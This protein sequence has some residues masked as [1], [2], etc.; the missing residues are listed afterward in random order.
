MNI[1][2]KY[3]LNNK[4]AV[5][6]FV[7]GL[8]FL[9]LISFNKIPKEGMP[10]LELNQILVTTTYPGAAPEDVELNVTIPL[11]EEINE[12]T[13]IDYIES[14]SADNMS[15]IFIQLDES[16]SK[17]EIEETVRDIR[18][19]VETV[20]DLPTEVEDAPLVQELK[21]DDIPIIEIAL[22][23]E[24]HEVLRKNARKL[25]L[26]LER[27]PLVSG[28]DKIGYFDKEIHIE[29]DPDALNETYFSLPEIAESIRK[30][31]IR[32]TSGTLES[33]RG[34]KNIMILNKFK[35]PM[36]VKDVILR[37]NFE[38]KT[39]RLHQVASVKLTEKDH[40]IKIRN[41][42]ENGISLVV[43]KKPDADII[44]TI[45]EIKIVTADVL[46][47]KYNYSFVSDQSKTTRMRL[48]LLFNNAISGFV[49]VLILLFLFLNRKAA[50]WTAF[51]IPFCFIAAFTVFPM[52]NI[53]FSA[54]ALAG[55]IVVLGIVVD[56]AIVVS[57]KIIFYQERGLPPKEA[58]Y[59]AV[60]DLIIPITLSTLTTIIAYMT[61]MSL[62]G[63]PGKFVVAIPVIVIMILIVS[64]IESFFFLPHHIASGR[65]F[66]KKEKSGWL[67]KLE[68]VY[69]KSL[70]I[71]LKKKILFLGLSVLLLAASLLSAKLFLKFRMFPQSAI[72]TF[73]IK[74]E[75]PN[76]Y[77]LID[78]ENIV[79]DI[80][81]RI[82]KLPENELESF[83]SRIGHHSTSKTKNYGDHE[84]WAIINV[85]LTPDISRNRTAAE[86]IAEIKKKNKF[87]KDIRIFFETKKVGPIQD[88]PITVHLSSND[89]NDLNKAVKVI[90]NILKDMKDL[91]VADIDNS[92][93]PGKEE[94]VINLDQNK[95][96]LIGISTEDVAQVLRIAYEGH[97][98]TDIQTLE[99]KIEYRLLLDEESRKSKQILEKIGVKNSTGSLVSLD[100][101]ISFDTKASELEILHRNGLRSITLSAS[102]RKSKISAIDAA[103]IIKKRIDSSNK[104]PE[105]VIIEI[106]GEALKTNIIMK[107]MKIAVFM[108]VVGIFLVLSLFLNSWKN[109]LIIIAVVP[110]CVIG[111]VIALLLHGQPV[112]MFVLLAAVGLTGVVVNDSIVMTDTL[113]SN[114]N[115]LS[116]GTSRINNIAL[117]ASQRLRP[118]L[119]TTLTTLGGL[120]PMAYGLGGYEKMISPMSLAFSWGLLFATIITLYIIPSIFLLSFCNEKN[121]DTKML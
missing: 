43:K 76:N 44:K 28:V 117:L 51:G 77:S 41:N 3:F 98:V 69:R 6:V 96:A 34:L 66:G 89:D 86:I 102:L 5:N 84:N 108:A 106:A 52:F 22:S 18:D 29:A 46:G 20:N 33:Y 121:G 118:I 42:G 13:G 70:I 31:N 80:E 67:L 92:R 88:K 38:Q 64:L 71:V 85:F 49:I 2:I 65:Q 4:I 113:S 107:D 115:K 12:I 23:D 94:L 54:I 7:F 114:I 78:T 21:T 59:S 63:R 100:K 55:L 120:L 15:S 37:S 48:R 40:K 32:S 95:L 83:T 75:C 82:K 72:E 56:D 45:E 93:K 68:N 53:T 110:F 101:F 91:G 62:G 111:I 35:D 119:L 90:A 27:I 14:V 16:Y 79:K 112:S 81:K 50:F 25:E 105:E 24:D 11:E 26:A 57:D 60:K 9:G 74:V 99:E 73:Y 17:K 109:A 10:S 19:A 47:K 104:I 1:L 61:L 8:F 116:Q 58:A 39:V 36:E 103:K 30:R 97:I 87:P